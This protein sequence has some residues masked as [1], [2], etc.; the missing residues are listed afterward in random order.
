MQLTSMLEEESLDVTWPRDATNTV[1]AHSSPAAKDGSREVNNMQP[2][3]GTKQRS[4]RREVSAQLSS[5]Q[6]SSRCVNERTRETAHACTLSKISAEMAVA[7]EPVRP[8]PSG[9]LIICMNQNR[10]DQRRQQ[11][12]QRRL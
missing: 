2:C 3:D 1:F 12:A 10:T 5:A 11:A 8:G 9:L 4:G 6:L 7:A